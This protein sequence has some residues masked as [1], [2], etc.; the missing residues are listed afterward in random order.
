M[1]TEIS[2][3]LVKYKE[4]YIE[5]ESSIF[6]IQNEKFEL[7]DIDF[8]N[9]FLNNINI[10]IAFLEHYLAYKLF[11]IS[12][13]SNYI[14]IKK[15]D[16]EFQ[17]NILAYLFEQIIISTDTDGK[18]HIQLSNVNITYVS[19]F[20]DLIKEEILDPFVLHFA[21]KNNYVDDVKYTAYYERILKK[22]PSDC[23]DNPFIV[24]LKELSS[25]NDDV[26]INVCV[27]LKSEICND[28]HI[29][30]I[31]SNWEHSY[32]LSFALETPTK[33]YY[34]KILHLYS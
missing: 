32:L 26:I 6:I 3:D 34:N 17:T 9:Y 27:F 33:N 5:D 2:Y 13:N 23:Y 7:C 16:V 20:E 11:S 29:S 8:K 1:L 14:Y 15:D 19:L 12:K 24:Y 30:A 21:N 28:E 4:S 18:Q 31:L 25:N 22:S 10:Q